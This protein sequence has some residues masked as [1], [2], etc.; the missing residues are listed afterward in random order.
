[1]KTRGAGAASDGEDPVVAGSRPTDALPPL[2]RANRPA[3]R[4]R[5][6]VVP[7]PRLDQALEAGRDAALTLVA[8]PAGYGKTTAVRAWCASSNTALAWVTLDV[9]DNDPGRFWNYVATAVDRIRDGLGRRALHR[10]Q[11]SGGAVETAID[12]LMN[13][14]ADFGSDL[15][16]VLDDAQ[17]VTDDNCLASVRY[18][19][20]RLPPAGRLIVITRAD[21]ALGLARLRARGALAEVRADDLAFTVAETRT[22]LVDRAGLQL[23]D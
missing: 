14:I 20:E 21:P 5:S 23:G 11:V 3:P 16:V 2:A 17:T 4:L 12:E 10:L 1:M 18:A 15:A 6:G 13:G 9:G 7:R 22:L 19:I 8:A